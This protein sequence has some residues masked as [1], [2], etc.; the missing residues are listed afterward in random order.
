MHLS[1]GRT[2]I[3]KTYLACLAFFFFFLIV[4]LIIIVCPLNQVSFL[5][6]FF[7]DLFPGT[8]KSSMRYVQ[9]LLR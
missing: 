5:I 9:F 8:V 1:S 4:S 2:E 3:S 7:F 6:L